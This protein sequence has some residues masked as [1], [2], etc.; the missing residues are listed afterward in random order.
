MQPAG[1]VCI[2]LLCSVLVA[3]CIQLPGIHSISDTPDPVIG[4]WIGGEPPESDMH[5][6]FY[7][8]RTFFSLNFIIYS[9]EVTDTGTWTKIESGA[10]STRSVSGEITNWTY[11]SWGDTLYASKIPQRKYYRYKG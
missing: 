2:L 7:E 10:Y 9:G 6:V 3:G 5:V 8:N 4:Q 1:K 11:D